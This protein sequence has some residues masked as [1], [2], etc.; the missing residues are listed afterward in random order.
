MDLFVIKFEISFGGLLGTINCH[1]I[2]TNFMHIYYVKGIEVTTRKSFEFYCI[3]SLNFHQWSKFVE[4]FFVLLTFK[5]VLV[6][7]KMYM[8]KN[9]V[10]FFTFWSIFFL[11]LKFK[12]WL[13]LDFEHATL[14]AETIHL[15]TPQVLGNVFTLRT[16]RIRFKM[17]F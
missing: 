12:K 13:H 3:E 17:I 8:L 7:L 9:G 5:L 1:P 14:L 15:T 10:K 11:H 4:H 6:P 2:S 16:L